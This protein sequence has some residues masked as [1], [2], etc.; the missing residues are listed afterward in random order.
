MAHGDQ[1]GRPFAAE[2]ARNLSDRQDISLFHG[3]LFHRP[4]GLFTE[5]DAALGHGTAFGD[6]LPGD[7]HHAGIALP[8]EMGKFH[9]AAVLSRS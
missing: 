9:T 6:L 8:V 4:E 5:T 2:N 1:I 7:I 3:F